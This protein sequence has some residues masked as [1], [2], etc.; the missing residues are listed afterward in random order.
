MRSQSRKM[1]RNLLS[2]LLVCLTLPSYA[3]DMSINP[4]L[5]TFSTDIYQL[6]RTLFWVCLG[7]GLVLS[8]LLVHSML[9]YRKSA[10]ARPTKMQ[11]SNLLELFWL[12]VP[13]ILLIA[14]AVPATLAL[15]H[16]DTKTQHEAQHP[17]SDY[18]LK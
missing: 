12:S 14:M 10:N 5:S 13:C 6:H 8:L 2:G 15:M 4:P 18:F 3:A 1:L 16:Y 9:K 11:E 17:V 7:I